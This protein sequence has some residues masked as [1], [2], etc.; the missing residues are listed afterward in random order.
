MDERSRKDIEGIKKSKESNLRLGRVGMALGSGR[1]KLH[2]TEHGSCERII[3]AVSEAFDPAFAVSGSTSH[4]LSIWEVHPG[5][6]WT[7]QSYG[8][9][10]RACI[11]P[12]SPTG[13]WY[14]E[15]NPPPKPVRTSSKWW[16]RPPVWMTPMMVTRKP[17]FFRTIWY[18]DIW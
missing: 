11:G 7:E 4:C 5:P 6:L 3:F 8:D 18:D 16:G 2:E 13:C 17:Y 12:V 15:N 9:P 10:K 14:M 1:G